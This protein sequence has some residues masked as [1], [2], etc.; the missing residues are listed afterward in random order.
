MTIPGIWCGLRA[1]A[2]YGTAELVWAVMVA[3]IAECGIP[4]MS[5]TDNGTV[6]TGRLRRLRSRPSR[7]TYAPW[8]RAPSTPPR[9]TP[10]PAARSNGPGRP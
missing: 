1:A 9:I 10:R 3:A 5:L 4:S 2:G 6:Y 7:S 8:A